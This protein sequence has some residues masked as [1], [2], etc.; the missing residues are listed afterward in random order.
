MAVTAELINQDLDMFLCDADK[1]PDI[2]YLNQPNTRT[3]E[4]KTTYI[5]TIKKC[6]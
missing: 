5:Y 4:L 6:R 2:L 3:E 1:T